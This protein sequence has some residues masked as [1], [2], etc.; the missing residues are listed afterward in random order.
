MLLR[1]A[2]VVMAGVGLLGG[3]FVIWLYVRDTSAIFAAA[4]YGA[5]LLL[6]SE[7]ALWSME[8][9]PR[10]R[11]GSVA[12]RRRALAIALLVASSLAAGLSAAAVAR[13]P[14]P[15][16]LVLTVTGIAGL[17]AAIALVAVVLWKGS[18]DA[19]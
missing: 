4:G 3:E 16:S 18:G 1:Q 2:A 7:V 9:R 12:L 11:G 13:A 10:Q 8:L 14:L 5:A 6:I 17:L 15:G 19:T